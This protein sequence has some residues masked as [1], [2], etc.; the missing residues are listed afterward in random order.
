MMMRNR[1]ER[2][3]NQRKGRK[4]RIS[5]MIL[6]TLDG[7]KARQTQ[8]AGGASKPRPRADSQ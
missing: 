1:K 4:I 8:A 3:D 5:K 7:P 6:W 2:Q